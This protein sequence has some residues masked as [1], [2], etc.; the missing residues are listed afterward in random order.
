MDAT[1]DLNNCP[2]ANPS[3]SLFIFNSMSVLP[4]PPT[5]STLNSIQAYYVCSY[6]TIVCIVKLQR[7]A[8]V[9]V[10]PRMSSFCF[11]N[12]S[13]I[14]LSKGAE[15]E[16]PFY[17]L[18]YQGD[19]NALTLLLLIALCHLTC[20]I[21][22]LFYFFLNFL[23]FADDGESG[24]G[25]VHSSLQT[26][27]AHA[28]V[29]NTNFLSQ[30]IFDKRQWYQLFFFFFNLKYFSPEIFFILFSEYFITQVNVRLHNK[31]FYEKNE[32]DFDI[33]RVRASSN[34]T[35]HGFL[36]SARNSLKKFLLIFQYKKI[37]LSLLLF[38]QN[39]YQKTLSRVTF[40]RKNFTSELTYFFFF[41]LKINL[42]AFSNK[43][44]VQFKG[45]ICGIL[46]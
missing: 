43:F 14:H 16:S 30:F 2:S 31:I 26:L 34:K 41:L 12:S 38:W 25:W 32:I 29:L 6:N 44:L 5:K 28:L 17:S 4:R 39:I 33:N 11:Y 15:A 45:N 35:F 9:D 40:C 42:P 22:C 1:V 37:F 36:A 8:L 23:F 24:C 3:L 10:H 7:R 46:L 20:L 21:V 18:G 19:I 27:P 13:V